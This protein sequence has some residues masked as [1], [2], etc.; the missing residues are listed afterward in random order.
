MNCA[1]ADQLT[2]QKKIFNSKIKK[3]KQTRNKAQTDQGN[4]R[5]IEMG[6]GSFSLK[7]FYQIHA[8][9]KERTHRR[10]HR[11]KLKGKG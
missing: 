11:R 4:L 6:G 9:P 2:L 10:I 3:I 5:R 1:F 8:S 7:G